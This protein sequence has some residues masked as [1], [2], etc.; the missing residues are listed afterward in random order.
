MRI[1][2]IKPD[3]WEDEGLAELDLVTRLIYVALWNESDDEGRLR[4]SPRYLRARLFPYDEELD[5]GLHL[6]SL[7][8]TGRLREYSCRGQTY[9]FLPNFNRHQRISKPS[10]S[11]LPNPEEYQ[12]VPTHSDTPTGKVEE[13][14]QWERERERE[15]ERECGASPTAPTSPKA[16]ASGHAV[17]D[18]ICIDAVR[19]LNIAA[20]TRYA[21]D[22]GST[23]K[24][25]RA[26]V[27]KRHT[28]AEMRQVIDAKALEWRATDM[29]KYLRPS[30][31]FG[32]KFEQ[33]FAEL[34]NLPQG[35]ESPGSTQHKPFEP[36]PKQTVDLKSPEV[37]KLLAKHDEK[38]RERAA[39]S[40]KEAKELDDVRDWLSD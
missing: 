40:E 18:A 9:L 10:K 33:Y 5:M 35:A 19:H 16:R 15:R 21:T 3:F 6:S 31:L 13:E 8:A 36:S 24:L 20:G 12:E 2:T 32:S 14:G 4:G 27:A 7:K 37:V 25:I 39:R 34:Q 38:K 23:R 22:A 17:A 30:T 1:R 28:L 26:L 29:A 11:R